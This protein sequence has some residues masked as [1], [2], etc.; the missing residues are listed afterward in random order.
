MYL[1]KIIKTG[2]GAHPN[3]YS[4]GT[5]GSFPGINWLELHVKCLLLFSTSMNTPPIL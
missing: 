2:P 4:N 3:P 1:L 5:G